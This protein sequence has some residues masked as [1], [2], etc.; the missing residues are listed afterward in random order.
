MNV[1]DID[2]RLVTINHER[3]RSA[4]EKKVSELKLSMANPKFGQLVPVIVDALP[5]GTY[6]L[7]AGLHRLVAVRALGWPTISAVLRTDLDEITR[8]EIELEENIRRL[9]M[10]WLDRAKAI[11]EIDKLRRISNPNWTV[12]QTAAVADVDRAE[13]SRSNTI[14]KMIGLFPELAE[15]KS[16]HQAM[17]KA[18]DK[19]QQVIR[20]KEVKDAPTLYASVEE[21][22]ALGDST[23]WIRGLPDESIHFICTDPPFGIDYDERK[24]DTAGAVNTYTD[25]RESYYRIL[26]MAPELY[27]VLKPDSFMVWFLGV[28]WYEQARDAFR[29]A[30]FTVDEIP[31]I[32]D[33]S[34]GGCGTS[35][36]DRWFGR[37]YDIALHC[38]KGEAKLVQ[39]GKSNIIRIPPINSSQRDLVVERPVE[40]YAELIRRCTRPGEIV[41][42]FFVGSGSCPAAAV[43]LG[44]EYIGCELSPERRAVALK[45]ILAH[46]PS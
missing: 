41:A 1:L 35:R 11:S 8:R 39:R 4:D 45:K 3:F 37:A 15:S 32:W 33:R 25:D 43:S 12:D 27:R 19:A 10:T 38:C 5:D 46:T 7:I 21:R 26:G 6:E 42:D 16:M 36:P 34:D 28:S 13:V 20:V 2:H 14:V 9:D 29:S 44:R 40:L 24:S 18:K 23:D 31:V 30:G 17:I 22:I